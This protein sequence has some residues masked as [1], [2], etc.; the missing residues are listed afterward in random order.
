MLVISVGGYHLEWD[1]IS[2][3]RCYVLSQGSPDLEFRFGFRVLEARVG[4]DR[5]SAS[6]S[7]RRLC[8][9]TCYLAMGGGHVA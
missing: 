5:A 6:G 4:M 7:L 3:R 9:C 8:F 2:M 1:N